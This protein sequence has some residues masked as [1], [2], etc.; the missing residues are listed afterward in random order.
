MT[1]IDHLKLFVRKHWII[2]SILVLAA[3]AM[4][5]MVISV[6]LNFLYF[7]DPR[8]QDIALKGWMTPR[9][10]VMSYDLPKPFVAEMLGLT[11][12]DQRGMPMRDVAK[13]M[14]VTLEELTEIVR[15]SATAFREEQQ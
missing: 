3:C 4:L 12:D 5:W 2:V 9:Y 8:N 15:T 14:G 7:N 1:H 6:A 13:Q 10:V 11:S